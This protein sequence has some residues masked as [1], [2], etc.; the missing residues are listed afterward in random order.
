[1]NKLAK[2]L[3]TLA[4]IL[5]LGFIWLC[6]EWLH[7]LNSPIIAKNKPAVDIVLA[8]GSSVKSLAKQ[9]FKQNIIEQPGFFEFLVRIRGQS[10][11]LQSGEYR[12]DPGITPI[13][14]LQKM[15]T[16]DVI[17]H[18][19]TI[20]D[21]WTFQKLLAELAENPDVVHTLQGLSDAE[22][23][24]KIGK[25]GEIPEGR[26]FP[27]T[28]KFSK[29]TKDIDILNT[30]YNLM[31]DKLNAAWN[32]RAGDAPYSCPYKALIAA[33]IIEK[34]AALASERPIISGIIKRRLEKNMYLQLDPTVIYGL[35][36]RYNGN[37]RVKDLRKDTPFNTYVHKGLPPTPI[38]MPSADAID[39]VL[40]PAPGDVLYF[41]AKGD[42]SHEF[43]ATLK[44]QDAAIKKYQLNKKHEK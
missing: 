5:I 10:Q 37:L 43:S 32:S 20:V 18:P 2:I 29:G 13:Q 9:L 8:Q 44:E 17:L 33:S 35:G 4:I 7:F 23:M 6:A 1:M 40:H 31:Q 38:C 36:D 19:F 34:E 28:Y 39:A 25:S 16:G 21:G 27:D 30:A 12:L 26:F 14:L 15:V 11:N 3:A 42:G 24:E 22:I 41:V